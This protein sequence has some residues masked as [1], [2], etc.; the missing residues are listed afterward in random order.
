VLALTGCIA[1]SSGLSKKDKAA[2]VGQVQSGL[3]ALGL[4]G[5]G[6]G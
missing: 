1:E 2:L 5:F 3:R 6:T 4:P